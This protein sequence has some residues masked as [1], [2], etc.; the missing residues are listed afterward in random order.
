[1]D[2]PINEY[3]QKYK[4][5]ITKDEI[6]EM[7]DDGQFFGGHTMSHPPLNQLT[8]DEQKKEII[9]SIEW[10]KKNFNINYSMFAFPFSDKFVSRKLI[11]ELFEYDS[12][13]KLFGNSGIKKD[14]H[15]SIYQRFSLDNPKKQIE[16]Q[17]VTENLYK[18]YNILIGSYS[19]QRK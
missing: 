5:Y 2:L 9:D 18:F 10:L 6:Q 4:P 15:G 11:Q 7:I 13:I 8:H 1:M 16:K 17:I 19:I 3:L 14:I 12:N